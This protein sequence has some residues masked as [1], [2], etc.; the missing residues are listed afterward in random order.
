MTAQTTTVSL[1][2]LVPVVINGLEA[3]AA[4]EFVEE[5][6]EVLR[7]AGDRRSAYGAEPWD[8]T[9]ALLLLELKHVRGR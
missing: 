7:G 8:F 3:M 6:L 5:E 4:V 2:H 1:I 9:S